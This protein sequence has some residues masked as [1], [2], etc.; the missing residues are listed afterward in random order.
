MEEVFGVYSLPSETVLR[1]LEET[2][3]VDYIHCIR[4]G[5]ARD[6]TQY[7]RKLCDARGKWFITREQSIREDMARLFIVHDNGGEP[8]FVRLR[9]EKIHIDTY[10]FDWNFHCRMASAEWAVDENRTMEEY[11]RTARIKA[12]SF[13][14]ENDHVE[15]DQRLS[16]VEDWVGVWAPEDCADERGGCAGNSV[17]I[18]LTPTSDHPNRYLL[19]TGSIVEFWTPEPVT[20]FESPIGNND[21][22]YP[23]GRTE[24][25]MLFL[26]PE[27]MSAVP[28]DNKHTLNDVGNIMRLRRDATREDVKLFL[29]RGDEIGWGSEPNM[30]P[31]WHRM[32]WGIYWSLSGAT[33]RGNHVPI[34]HKEIYARRCDWETPES[35]QTT[36]S[37]F[38]SG[39][40]DEVEEEDGSLIQVRLIYVPR[41]ETDERV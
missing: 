12:A 25:A 20:R 30:N 34:E 4:A 24:N 18:Q 31:V 10:P 27:E 22:P 23:F 36:S 26:L 7:Q 9:G 14:W 41:N 1:V 15:H 39:L 11:N 28:I 37:S 5:L 6:A 21:V 29:R 32:W 40:S 19:I 33:T 2:P 8:W 13:D 38:T 16:T 17:L 3:S 35:K